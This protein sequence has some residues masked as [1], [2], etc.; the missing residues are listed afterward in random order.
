[1][2]EEEEEEIARGRREEGCSTLIGQRLAVTS[3]TNMKNSMRLKV[4]PTGYFWE[5]ATPQ[6]R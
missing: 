4:T 6:S 1:M 5:Q 3:S 2:L